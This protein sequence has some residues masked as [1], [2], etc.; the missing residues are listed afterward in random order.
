MSLENQPV[1]SK[2]TWRAWVQK[3]KLS[4]RALARE[5]QLAAETALVPPA[6]G[7]AAHFLSVG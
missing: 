5:S 6:L 7:S 3:G 1:V 2:E 4:E